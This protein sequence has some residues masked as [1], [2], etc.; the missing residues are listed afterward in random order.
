MSKKDFIALADQIKGYNTL[1]LFGHKLQPFTQEQIETLATF[2][3]YQNSNFM[4]DRWL[5]YIAG[6]CG[7]NGGAVKK[8]AA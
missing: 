7:K 1:A 8:S 6:E 4:R 2:C 5:N 3:Q